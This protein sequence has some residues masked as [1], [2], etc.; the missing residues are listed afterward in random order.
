MTVS[1]SRNKISRTSTIDIPKSGGGLNFKYCS[2]GGEIF[3]SAMDLKYKSIAWVGNVYQKFEAMCLE[4]ED[5]MCQETAKYVEGQVQNVSASVKKFYSEV[6]Q[7]LV[8]PSSVDGVKDVYIEDNADTGPN[9][10]SKVIVEGNQKNP[11]IFDE[12]KIIALAVKH[13][14]P[15]QNKDLDLYK[16]SKTD[17]GIAPIL[18]SAVSVRKDS[19]P[20]LSAGGV[21]NKNHLILSSA[22]NPVNG[23]HSKLSL[24]DGYKRSDILVEE[25]CIGG[26]VV[27]KS[28]GNSVNESTRA[29]SCSGLHDENCKKTDSEYSTDIMTETEN[30]CDSTSSLPSFMALPDVLCEN[31]VGETQPSSPCSIISAETDEGSDDDKSK[32]KEGNNDPDERSMESIDNIHN[33]KLEESCIF[34]DSKELYGIPRGTSKH[35]SYKKKIRDA[36]ALRMSSAKKEYEQLAICYKNIDSQQKVESF[37]SS[38]LTRELDKKSISNHDFRESDWELL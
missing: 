4:V 20:A 16:K 35:R 27:A 30:L 22:S 29:S 33:L 31:K 38:F 3:V 24:C 36:F 34:V 7:D 10:N 11:P 8:P 25:I 12:S 14:S 1:H 9:K 23:S 2:F 32:L 13:S 19:I 26:N 18:P 28:I 15:Q 6:L 17:H 21:H 37:T 5:I